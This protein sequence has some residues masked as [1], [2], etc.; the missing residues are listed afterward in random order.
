MIDVANARTG[1]R[2]IEDALELLHA[3]TNGLQKSLDRLE[4]ILDA[5]TESRDPG[6][7]HDGG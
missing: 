2:D 3:V 1:V 4:P 5:A 6:G 7:T